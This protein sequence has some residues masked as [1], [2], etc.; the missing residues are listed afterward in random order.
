[1]K[2]YA[3][4]GAL[5]LAL[6]CV[7][8]GAQPALFNMRGGIA[9]NMRNFIDK[10][11]DEG[12]KAIVDSFNSDSSVRFGVGVMAGYAA[13]ATIKGIARAVVGMATGSAVLVALA[14]MNGFGPPGIGLEVDA[15]KLKS[16]MLDVVDVDHD[17]NFDMEDVESG[18]KAV[19]GKLK[20]L[21][22]KFHYFTLG[23]GAGV[24][25]AIF[26]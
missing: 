3:V 18:A 1:M 4:M 19:W 9:Q 8:A 24:M 25:A 5:A 26:N 14:K 21:V 17:G 20:P 16:S 12:P 6:S 13:L 2:I 7:E 22:K 23:F 15:D 11:Q 10:V